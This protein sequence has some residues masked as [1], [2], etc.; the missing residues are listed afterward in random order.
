MK[1]CLK[2]QNPCM[3]ANITVIILSQHSF[4]CSGMCYKYW[5][6]YVGHKINDQRL[7]LKK[8]TKLCLK[9]KFLNQT[10]NFLALVVEV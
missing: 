1:W 3:I 9:F 7:E 6:Q 5:S 2:G 10:L 4:K 8:E